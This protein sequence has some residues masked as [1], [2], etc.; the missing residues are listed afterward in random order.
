MPRPRVSALKTHP[1]LPTPAGHPPASD[2]PTSSLL[3]DLCAATRSV[4][5]GKYGGMAAGGS[6]MA[7]PPFSTSTLVVNPSVASVHGGVAKAPEYFH[8]RQM[9]L[10]VSPVGDRGGQ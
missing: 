10:D 2:G 1:P 4:A 5:R 9:K 7:P 8:R 6:H 3:A